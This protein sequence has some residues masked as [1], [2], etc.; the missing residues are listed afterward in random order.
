MDSKRLVTGTLVGAIAIS[1]VGYLL[2]E[3][4]FA[5]FMEAQLTVGMREAPIWWAGLLSAAAHAL[6]LTLVIGWAGETSIAGGLKVGAIVGFLL[7]FGAD[8]ILFAVFEF[9]TLSG[10]LTDSVLATVQYAVAGSAIGAVLAR[11]SAPAPAPA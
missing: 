5:A 8:M 1:V 10:A 9:S 7:W 4:L 6:L 3:V 2:Y 11:G